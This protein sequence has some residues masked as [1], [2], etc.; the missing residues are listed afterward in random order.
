MARLKNLKLF[1]SILFVAVLFIGGCGSKDEKVADETKDKP[2]ITTEAEDAEGSIEHGDGYG[3]TEFELEIDVEG[4][5]M[6]EM[7]YEA[8]EKLKAEYMNKLQDFDLKEKEAMDAIHEF[9]MEVRITK[10]TP[11]EEVIEK[12]LQSLHIDHYSKFNLEIL[13][14]EGTVLEIND[15]Q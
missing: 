15:T 12:I 4:E 1:S 5:D 6:I 10:D 3:F 11:K 8:E 13:F 9:F 2:L 14:D 7:D